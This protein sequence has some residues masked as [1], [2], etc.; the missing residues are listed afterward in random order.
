MLSLPKSWISAF[1]DRSAPESSQPETKEKTR[2]LSFFEGNSSLVESSESVF[3]LSSVEPVFKTPEV[4]LKATDGLRTPTTIWNRKQAPYQ[5]NRWWQNLVLKEGSSYLPLYPYVLQMSD[6]GMVICYPVLTPT[7]EYVIS[8]FVANWSMKILELGYMPRKLIN[9]DDLSASLQWNGDNDF[10]RMRAYFVR[11]SPYITVD[12]SNA[13]L[14]FSTIHAILSVVTSNG[15]TTVTFNN[16]QTWVFYASNPISWSHTMNKLVTNGAYSGTLRLAYVPESVDQ[17]LQVLDQFRSTFPVS[18]SV[19]YEFPNDRQSYV[20]YTFKKRGGNLPVL[21]LSLAHHQQ[22]LVNQSTVNLTGYR[23][24]KG[25]MTAVVGDQWTILENLNT[26]QWHAPRNVDP[27]LVQAIQEAL[28]VD[29]ANVEIDSNL[30]DPY[31]YGKS[32]AKIAKL[33]LMAEHVGMHY[34]ISGIIDKAK[35]YIEPWFNSQ[36]SN[37]LI[38]DNTWGGIITL[39]GLSDEQ[40]DFG[41]GMYNDHHFHYG[42]LIYT[43]AIIGKYDQGWLNKYRPYVEDLVRDYANPNGNDPFYPKFRC[44]DFYD[45]HS[46][47]SGL[48]DFFDGKNQESTSEAVNAYYAIYLLGLALN[49]Q[50][51]ANLGNLLTTMEI[52]SCRRYW[53]MDSSQQPP[54]WP[55]VFSKNKTVGILWNTKVDYSTWFGKNPEFIHCIQMLPFTPISHNLLDKQWIRELLPILSQ[56]LT[57]QDPPLSSGWR[58][59]IYMAKGVID[60]Q[61]GLTDYLNSDKGVDDGNTLTN[62]LYWFATQ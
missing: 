14:E 25:P 51:L 34:L 40:A 35:R 12:L 42:Y 26:I 54:V 24:I 47:A 61:G 60:K 29:A 22:C 59:F 38:Y 33:A 8:P 16:G 41:N 48:F 49:D 23:C 52:R 31:F 18:G 44:F 19:V 9:E 46:W 39:N 32:L 3:T 57:R 11:G 27:S 6:N 62:T 21:M 4:D 36:N 1:W 17:N 2:P 53:H 20:H 10:T 7:S 50:N 37:P 5:T 28:K 30:K 55:D 56:A 13:T 58:T 43:A 45:G 15:R